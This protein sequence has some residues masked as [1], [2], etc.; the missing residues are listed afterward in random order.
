MRSKLILA[1]IAAPVIAGA[2][3][4]DSSGFRPISM[5]EALRLA[6]D[7]N[8]SNVTAENAIRTQQNNVRQSRAAV[9]PTLTASAGQSKTAGQ[10][11][12]QNGTLVPF[13]S[14]WRY[15]TGLSSGVTLFDA[16]KMFADVRT[17]K[18]NLV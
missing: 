17:A 8:V 1:L 5:A 16:G 14:D 3:A 7:N 6:R 11:I 13:V 4:T 9:L 18:A 2:Q 15:N 12:G 10:Q